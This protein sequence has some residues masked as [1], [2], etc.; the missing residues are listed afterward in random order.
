[1]FANLLDE[2]AEPL[3][4]ELPFATT[5]SLLSKLARNCDVLRQKGSV[6]FHATTLLQIRANVERL[7]LQ[8]LPLAAAWS[9]ERVDVS[10]SRAT[11]H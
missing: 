8:R 6:S 5:S 3:G 9:Q 7:F 4:A 11:R 10:D 1:V 2:C